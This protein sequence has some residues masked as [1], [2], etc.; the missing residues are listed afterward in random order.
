V[1]AAT[2]GHR[3]GNRAA[4]IAKT[5]VSFYTTCMGRLHHLR[6][7][8]PPNIEWAKPYGNVEFVVLDYN[9]SDGLDEWAR[10]ALLPHIRTGL[11]VYAKTFRPHWFQMGKAKNV[12]ALLASG[13]VICNLDADNLIG[14]G[15]VEHIATLASPNTVVRASGNPGGAAGRIAMMR[16]DFVALGGYDERFIGW[17]YDEND[18]VERAKAS[19]FVVKQFAR[20]HNLYIDHSGEERERYSEKAMWK[21]NAINKALSLQAISSRQF[22]ANFGKPWGCEGVILNFSEPV[23]VGALH[24]PEVHRRVC[25]V[26]GRR[27]VNVPS[28]AARSALSRR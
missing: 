7:T 11:V 16:S 10:E 27:F 15:F 20:K 12:A 2:V 3:M 6:K 28:V 23:T 13:E 4:E 24:A 25:L 22:V 17:G 8:L 14:E 5:K 19:G 9:S 1:P 18:L 26:Q 21:T